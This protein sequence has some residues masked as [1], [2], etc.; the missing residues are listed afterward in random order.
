MTPRRG[1]PG[2]PR[3][4]AYG[5]DAPPREQILHAA[6]RL[7]VGRGFAATSTR[8]I[9]D[10][11]GIR[12]ASL[13]YHF[14]NKDEILAE[15]LERSVRPTVDKIDKI[16]QLVPPE[17]HETALYLLALVDVRTLATAPN[18]IGVLSR[19]PDVTSSAA[20][21]QFRNDRSEL[22]DAYGRLGASIARATIVDLVGRRSLGEMLVQ[23]VDTVINVRCAGEPA[24]PRMA[25]AVATT[26]LRM[27]GSDDQ[28]IMAASSAATQLL[29]AFHDEPLH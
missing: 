6:A 7:F 4:I 19:L 9:A 13:Y 15:L 12:Q 26:C 3:H 27:C 11:V 2:R 8:E 25:E 16:E 28:Q 20:F 10:A 21:E 29:E 18:N 17:T 22:V 1:R 5:G 14:A 23:V 24:G